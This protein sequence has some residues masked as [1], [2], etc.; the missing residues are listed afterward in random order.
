MAIPAGSNGHDGGIA[1]AHSPSAPS[2][3]AA[4]PNGRIRHRTPV[5]CPGRRRRQRMHVRSFPRRPQQ[6]SRQISPF[7]MPQLRT[8]RLLRAAQ[9]G[10]S[11][12]GYQAIFVPLAALISPGYSSMGG[13]PAV[14]LYIAALEANARSCRRQGLPGLPWRSGILVRCECRTGLVTPGCEADRRSRRWG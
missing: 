10:G 5:N 8:Q 3:S 13:Q 2:R 6:T 9:S 1:A 11:E 7:C 12:R 14:Y 4:C